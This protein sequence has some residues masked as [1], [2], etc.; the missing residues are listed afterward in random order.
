[1]YTLIDTDSW[2][3]YPHFRHFYDE[4]MCAISLCDDID[5]TDL[6]YTCKATDKSFYIAMLYCAS[7]TV[8]SHDEFKLTTVDSPE[9][10]FQMP[11]VW[12]RV[13]PS[14]NIFHEDSETYTSTFTM[15]DMD[16]DKF[17]DNCRDDIARA[18]RLHVMSVPCGGNIFEASCVPWRSFTS[19]GTTCESYP[20]SPIVVW[21]R[22]KRAGDKILIPLSIQINHAAADGFHLAR[23]INETEANCAEL[24]KNIRREVL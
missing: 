22:L 18:K 13:D 21:G 1:M 19:V 12:D 15:F 9:Y 24:A 6:F 20:L 5:V 23:F 16:F 7:L 4:E 2:R 10:E 3:R 14:H 8:N 11:A 17:Y